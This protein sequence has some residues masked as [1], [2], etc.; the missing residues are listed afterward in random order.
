MDV[1]S[2][3]P[4]ATAPASV[5]PADSKNVYSSSDLT[6]QE[7]QLVTKL[8]ARDSAVKAHEQAHIAAGGSLV[9]S[10][11][12]YTYQKGPNGVNYAVGGE[13]KIDTSKEQNDPEATI[14]KAQQIRRAALAPADPS[15]KDRAVAAKA[16]QLTTE[17]RADLQQQKATETLNNDSFSQNSNPKGQSI[18]VSV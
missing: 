10:G 3:P 2:A 17:A 11:P 13:V 12:S 9:I 5:K 15:A 16:T 1:S 6:N 4:I 18:D 14:Q 7:K 8:Q